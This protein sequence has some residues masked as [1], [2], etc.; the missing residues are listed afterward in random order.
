[1][2]GAELQVKVG[3]VTSFV[4]KIFVVRASTM[5]TTNILHHENDQLYGIFVDEL[6][7]VFLLVGQ[8][9][10]A[11]RML[12]GLQGNQGGRVFRGV[13]MIRAVLRLPYLQVFQQDLV[14]R[15]DLDL[16]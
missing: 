12:R 10:R 5:K 14:V 16:P 13:Q 9:L 11:D 15:F 4:G 8:S 3:K 2:V 7:E 1:M 6:K